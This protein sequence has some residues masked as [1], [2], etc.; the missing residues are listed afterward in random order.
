MGVCS[1]CGACLCAEVLTA[2]SGYKKHIPLD[3]VGPKWKLTRNTEQN[4]GFFF[5]LE[6]CFGREPEGKNSNNVKIFCFDCFR[7]KCLEFPFCNGFCFEFF[8][9]CYIFSDIFVY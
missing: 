6:F 5:P 4:V 2:R 3:S 1:V 9:F 8:W 7:T